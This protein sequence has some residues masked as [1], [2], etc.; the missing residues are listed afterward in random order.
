MTKQQL[1]SA[2][3]AINSGPLPSL[4]HSLPN[5]IIRGQ[6]LTPH[7]LTSSLGAPPHPIVVVID[8]DSA[9]GLT[10]N[11]S[12]VGDLAFVVGINYG[13]V[14]S[15][16]KLPACALYDRTHMQRRLMT[17]FTALGITA[18]APVFVAANFFPFLTG[19]PW[20]KLN[21]IEE[22][23]L[24]HHNG[25]TD[26]IQHV[27]CTVRA[28]K[29]KWVIFHG[30]NNGVPLLGHEWMRHHRKLHD[31]VENVV[32]CDNLAYGSAQISNAIMY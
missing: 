5:G 6:A 19:K 7:I 25:F 22:M 26:P 17:V 13:Q 27:D 23:L 29:P 14:A 1:E 31:S 4:A 11:S 8:S 12:L 18:S 15:S 24:V 21:S 2:V 10:S 20:G 16:G 32:F 3:T 28:L 30:A 9:N